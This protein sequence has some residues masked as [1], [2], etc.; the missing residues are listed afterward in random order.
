MSLDLRVDHAAEVH[1]VHE[2]AGHELICELRK[3]NMVLYGMFTELVRKLYRQNGPYVVGCPDVRWDPDPQKT[4]IWI[5]TELNWNPEHPEFL[6][7]IFVR[8]GEVQYSSPGGAAPIASGMILRDA[9]YKTLRTG[10]TAVSFCH[11]GGNAGEACA[12]CDNTRFW[13]SD[14]AMPIRRDLVLSGFYE[15]G[16]VPLRQYQRDSKERWQ[17][18]TTFA[19]E[20][21]EES[22][23]KLESP[24]LRSI[25]ADFLKER[26]KYGILSARKGAPD[27]HHG[28]YR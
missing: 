10:R 3:T 15:V 9:V 5:D 11:V 13:L 7:A 28:E 18:M 23:L 24:I 21:N 26:G 22:S 25:D 6:P 17:S 2:L 20:W 4:G 27:Q 16:S 1:E 14:F 12:L 8:L 19:V